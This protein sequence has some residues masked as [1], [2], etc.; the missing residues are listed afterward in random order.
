MSSLRTLQTNFLAY[1]RTPQMQ[2][3]GAVLDTPT[4]NAD[5][6]LK[7]YADAYRLRLADALADNYPMLHALL[8]DEAFAE[9]GASYL[10]THP[11]QHFSI[12]HFGHRLAEFVATH[13]P[14]T[15]QPV[16]ADLANFEW[17]LRDVFDAADANVLR[18]EDLA[19]IAPEQWPE[20]RFQLHPTARRLDLTWNAPALWKALD[21]QRDPPPP[22]LNNSITA[23]F[24]W[25]HDLN[26]NFRTLEADEA[27]AIDA[28]RHDT[29]F[30]EL[31]TGLCEWA[32]EHS[33]AV[34]AAQ[35]LQRWLSEGVLA[36]DTAPEKTNTNK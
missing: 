11:S 7:I 29:S 8:G 1:L 3:H 35:L 36:T 16:L 25:R 14:Y 10:D 22:Q 23:W 28:L 9:L 31:C 27:W 15:Q 26:I 4:V 21:Q 17:A 13:A 12:R 18:V 5:L 33:A 20:L 6:R 19:E 24:I 2:M 30:A 34:R 32:G